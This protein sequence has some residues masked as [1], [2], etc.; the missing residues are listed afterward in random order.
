[1]IA[2][3]I[4]EEQKSHDIGVTTS[5]TDW[6]IGSFDRALEILLKIDDNLSI[7]TQFW[8]AREFNDSE[9][10]I[11]FLQIWP[12]TRRV[13]NVWLVPDIVA[14]EWL[15]ERGVPV[16]ECVEISFSTRAIRNAFIA[17][18]DRSS[19]NASRC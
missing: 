9:T 1:M 16:T 6:F 19:G 8:T 3:E 13:E 14:L 12:D 15:R 11:A 17:E 5:L 10:E 4:V 7:A 18:T 2:N